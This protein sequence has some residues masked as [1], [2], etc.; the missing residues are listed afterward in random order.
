MRRQKFL[1]VTSAGDARVTTKRPRPKFGE[2]VYLLTIEIP[3]AWSGVV[4]EIDVVMP[5]PPQAAV[6][7]D[8]DVM[9]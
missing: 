2:A 4:G 6:T 1:I 9:G 8:R 3:D 5:E 7:L